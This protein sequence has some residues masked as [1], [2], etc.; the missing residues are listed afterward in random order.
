MTSNLTRLPSAAE[1][2]PQTFT[3]HADPLTYRVFDT[4]SALDVLAF[5]LCVRSGESDSALEE[6]GRDPTL[7]HDCL[8]C[9]GVPPHVADRVASHDLRA[10]YMGH[11]PPVRLTL[12]AAVVLHVAQRLASVG[13]ASEQILAHACRAA[14]RVIDLT[15]DRTLNDVVRAAALTHARGLER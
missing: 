5:V 10:L 14:D 12:G 8:T 7:A 2:L 13:T 9:M 3:T 15:P 6:I 11:H 1:S 4:T